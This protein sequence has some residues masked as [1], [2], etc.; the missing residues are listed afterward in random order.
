MRIKEAGKRL[1]LVRTTYAPECR[2]GIDKMIASISSEAIHV[3]LDVVPLLTPEEIKQVEG[4]LMKRYT[5]KRKES[6]RTALSTGFA[7][8]ATLATDALRCPE[9]VDA[10]TPEEVANLWS[11]L[12]RVQ[13]SME[14]AKLPRPKER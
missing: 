3:P 6:F 12:E 8:A 11:V 10:L 5:A 9:I 4:A 14:R 13:W 1:Q 7:E 2:R